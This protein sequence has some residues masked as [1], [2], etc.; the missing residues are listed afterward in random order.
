MKQ[1][2]NDRPS[3]NCFKRATKFMLA[4]SKLK[5]Q[6]PQTV[7]VFMIIYWLAMLYSLYMDKMR[8]G[9]PI[10][11][12]WV[13]LETV[14]VALSSMGLI[15]KRKWGCILSLLYWVFLLYEIIQHFIGELNSAHGRKE[16]FE[17]INYNTF[18]FYAVALSIYIIVV[19]FNRYWRTYRWF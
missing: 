3:S 13:Y 1:N 2:S 15:L 9:F 16:Q 17:V 19:S 6:L 14:F 10:Y 18:G 5:V 7:G 11:L 8:F 12:T 4:K